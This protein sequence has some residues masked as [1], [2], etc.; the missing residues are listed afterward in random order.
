MTHL[1]RALALGLLLCAASCTHAD[2]SQ[3]GP[4]AP[5]KPAG[6]KL[7]IYPATR[8]PYPVENLASAR[9]NCVSRQSCIDRLREE[10]CDAGADVIYGFAEGVQGMA[11]LISA[12]FARKTG[13]EPAPNWSGAPA[14]DCNPPCSPGFA[15][16]A[17]E[18][19]PQC[20]PACDK[21]EVCSR[22]R[23]C[24]SATAAK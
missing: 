13:N 7:D 8:P 3:I 1:R 15:C 20:N 2:V 12:T 18:C 6:C 19:E 23:V 14:G 10:A 4:R 22:K 24:E 21:G 11:T 16:K 9:A 5:A 17:G